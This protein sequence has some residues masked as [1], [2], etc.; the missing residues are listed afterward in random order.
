[1]H[2]AVQ[3]QCCTVDPN[4]LQYNWIRILKIVPHLDPD[5]DPESFHTVTL[6]K[7]F[8]FKIVYFNNLFF[9]IKHRK[10]GTQIMA[11]EESSACFG[12]APMSIR[13][14]IRVPTFLHSDPGSTPPPPPRSQKHKCLSQTSLFPFLTVRIRIYYTA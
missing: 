13:I 4:T 5:T 9:E 8:T 2:S 12:S 10:N 3:H 7:K 11:N 1:M 6:Y 14:R